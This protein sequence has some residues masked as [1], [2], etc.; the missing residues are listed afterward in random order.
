MPD[1]KQYGIY[2]IENIEDVGQLP[3]IEVNTGGQWLF[4]A[5]FDTKELVKKT[6]SV[7]VVTYEVALKLLH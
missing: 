4:V 3:I 5:E 7:I 6:W 1:S 2:L